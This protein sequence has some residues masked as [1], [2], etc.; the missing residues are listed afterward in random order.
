MSDEQF[1]LMR[2]RSQAHLH[3]SEVEEAVHV[4][5]GRIF[6]IRDKNL[7]GKNTSN[8]L[9]SIFLPKKKEN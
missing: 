4:S 7:W 2:D 9:G 3:V 8:I 5:R 1:V 6:V